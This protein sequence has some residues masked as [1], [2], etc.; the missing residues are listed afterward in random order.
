MERKKTKA[1]SPAVQELDT[2]INTDFDGYNKKGP[3]SGTGNNIVSGPPSQRT[4]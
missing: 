3:V 1:V 2:V 4:V